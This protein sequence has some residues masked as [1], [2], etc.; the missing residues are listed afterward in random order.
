MKKPLL[1][2]VFSILIPLPCFADFGDADFPVAIFEGGP[3]SYH[4]AWCGKIGNNCRVVF[5]GE[6]MQVVGSGGITRNQYLQYRFESDGGEYY[7]YITYMSSNGSRRDSLFLFAH[8]E[9]QRDFIKAFSRWR[10]Q[11]TSPIPNYRYPNSQGPQDTQGRDGGMNPY[12][13]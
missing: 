6:S 5:S 1:L 4:D 12:S 8:I 9:A 7:N 3:K 13:R 10:N 2:L 11:E